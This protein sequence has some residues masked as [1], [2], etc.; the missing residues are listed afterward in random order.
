MKS[1]SPHFF[2]IFNLNFASNAYTLKQH[3]RPR[4]PTP[5]QRLANAHAFYL[6]VSGQ[7][8]VRPFGSPCRAELGRS[9]YVAGS[10]ALAS[11]PAVSA[12]LRLNKNGSKSNP[13]PALGRQ[14]LTGT[15]AAGTTIAAGVFSKADP[16]TAECQNATPHFGANVQPTPSQRLANGSCVGWRCVS[17]FAG[18]RGRRR[19][20]G[21]SVSSLR[22]CPGAGLQRHASKRGTDWLAVTANRRRAPRVLS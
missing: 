7:R 22:L 14:G 10:A 19:H 13:V 8:L 15:A 2:A 6:N 5:G 12:W 16:L 1:R 18:N 4:R 17:A 3:F 9:S 20:A 11:L 21:G